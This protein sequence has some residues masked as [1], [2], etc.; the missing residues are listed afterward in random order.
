MSSFHVPLVVYAKIVDDNSHTFGVNVTNNN[1]L[2]CDTQFSAYKLIRMPNW[3]YGEHTHKYQYFFPTID[4]EITGDPQLFAQAV[5]AQNA[6]QPLLIKVN[7]EAG[8]GDRI[9]AGTR[10]TT[11]QNAHQAGDALFNR[12]GRRLKRHFHLEAVE[13]TVDTS[14][15]YNNDVPFGKE[16]AGGPREGM[17]M[18]TEMID[19]STVPRKHRSMFTAIL[20]SKIYAV[21]Y[22]E[23]ADNPTGHKLGK[24]LVGKT[25]AKCCR[26]SGANN[27]IV[28]IIVA[29][30]QSGKSKEML[31]SAIFN[32][33]L[34]RD[35]L[36]FVR[37]VGGLQSIASFK[38]D[39]QEFAMLVRDYAENVLD[40]DMQVADGLID[41]IPVYDG[42]AITAKIRRDGVVERGFI[43]VDRTNV[44]KLELP[45]RHIYNEF[46]GRDMY[47]LIIDE[48][49]DF[50]MSAN[51][52]RGKTENALFVKGDYLGGASIF[53]ASHMSIGF[54]ATFTAVITSSKTGLDGEHHRF[55]VFNVRPSALYKGHESSLPEERRI[56]RHETPR[57]KH[58]TARQ[59]AGLTSYQIVLHSNAGVS[60]M[61]EHMVSK[62]DEYPHI[63]ALVA[64]SIISENKQKHAVAEALVQ[65]NRYA[66]V[67]LITFIQSQDQGFEFFFDVAN[68][69]VDI[70]SDILASALNTA[71]DGTQVEFKNKQITFKVEK[72]DKSFKVALNKEMTNKTIQIGYDIVKMINR[73]AGTKTFVL[74][75]SFSLANR[76]ATYKPSDHSMP[77]TH[78]YGSTKS[79][80]AIYANDIKQIAGRLCSVD[81]FDFKRYLFAPKEFL[82][83]LTTSYVV[84]NQILTRLS[85]TNDVETIAR[86]FDDLLTQLEADNL[87]GKLAH[88]DKGTVKS[89]V[90]KRGH[91]DYLLENASNKTARLDTPQAYVNSNA[92]CDAYDTTVVNV[93]GA[94]GAE[95]QVHARANLTRS[96]PNP[97]GDVIPETWYQRAFEIDL[98]RAAEVVEA[99]HDPEEQRRAWRDLEL[100][101]HIQGSRRGHRSGNNGGLYWLIVCTL[102]IRNGQVLDGIDDFSALRGTP[103]ETTFQF[104]N[105]TRY[106]PSSEGGNSWR[107]WCG[108]QHLKRE[109]NRWVL[110]WH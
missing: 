46:N 102:F 76:G 5:H 86:T 61:F 28:N 25:F 55:N 105:L 98:R 97:D 93:A 15:P 41:D 87:L 66:H 6:T 58:L 110:S 48:F 88:H 69:F 78:Q 90:L 100:E 108:G 50:I 83:M 12:A 45:F 9:R 34:G 42:K 17:H 38:V 20:I 109:G 56:E 107:P 62:Y 22:G 4:Q 2:I 27:N 92:E 36:V 52:E 64:C 70:T 7:Q 71:F 104:L 79:K 24:Y 14:T 81:E 19:L 84:E 101:C 85:G 67:P 74:C 32:I 49:D 103:F 47:T 63:S 73:L 68:H 43:Y 65:E 31:A 3:S 91:N 57:K 33:F 35:S 96:A 99:I 21:L 44:S 1:H 59:K 51:G 16:L 75:I 40:I 89:Q 53:N 94:G 10:S 72:T 37:N 77:L 82:D 29:L 30:T 8:V 18:D 11:R 13:R 23:E 95:E 60:Q 54:T 26:R 39:L 80:N 106:R